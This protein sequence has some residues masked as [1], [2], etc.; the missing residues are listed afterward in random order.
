MLCS[1]RIQRHDVCDQRSVKSALLEAELTEQVARLTLP[2]DWQQD[3]IGYL[4]DEEG[5]A[6]LLSRR[7]ALDEHF[8]QVKF[9]YEQEEISRQQYRREW[10]AYHHESRALDPAHRTDLDLS[11]A[12][13]LL[14]DMS[15]LWARLT[16]L[17]QKE[18]AQSLLRVAIVDEQRVISWHWY[19]P[20]SP[21]FRS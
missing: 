10:Q 12:W 5:L 18:L 9:L 7:R 14:S 17:E 20:F 2:A 4:L 13:D 21:L 19:R 6:G 11:L 15:R 16:P 8:R 3:V 1:T